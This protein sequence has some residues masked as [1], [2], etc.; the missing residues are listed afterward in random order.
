MDQGTPQQER[1]DQLVELLKSGRLTETDYMRAR[2]AVLKNEEVPA[3]I[4]LLPAPRDKLFPDENPMGGMSSL[5]RDARERNASGGE[6]LLRDSNQRITS[7]FDPATPD[8]SDDS[9]SSWG[10]ITPAID[11]RGA[12]QPL[13]VIQNARERRATREYQQLK[14]EEQRS[15]MFLPFLAIFGI[16][17]VATAVMS[18]SGGSVQSAPEIPPPPPFPPVVSQAPAVPPVAKAV[19]APKKRVVT[20]RPAMPKAIQRAVAAP[21]NSAFRPLFGPEASA[22]CSKHCA[23]L[24]TSAQ[25]ACERGC[26]RFALKDYARRISH[27]APNPNGDARKIAGRCLIAAQELPSNANATQWKEALG[28]AMTT[29]TVRAPKANDYTSLRSLYSASA[30]VLDSLAVTANAT[31]EQ[32]TITSAARQATCLRANLALTE[33]A[34]GL[35]QRRQDGYSLRFYSKLKQAL[36][37]ITGDVEDNFV[38]LYRQT[39]IR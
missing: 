9:R 23:K 22:E 5:P 39:R 28:A 8:L 1:L 3:D 32:K 6:R 2:V 35:S 15:S 20:T 37:A 34:I 29:V 26:S 17:M 33:L 14:D 25:N 7:S 19:V 30:R 31:E 27:A 10:S 36:A 16:A 38:L 4:V 18:S 13:S 12:Q 24:S 21:T 11:L